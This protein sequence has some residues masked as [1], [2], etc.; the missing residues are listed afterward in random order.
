MSNCSH[1]RSHISCIESVPIFS[2]L[3]SDEML[4]IAHITD[5]ATYNKGDMIYMSG[6][7]GG[8]LYVLH[9][10]R[11]KISR[12]SVNG[13]EQVIRV[14]G[15][16]EFMGELSLLSSLPLN[17]NAEALETCSMCVIDGVK[18]KELMSKYTSIAFKVMDEISK[19]LEKAEQLIESISLNPVEQRL[20]QA[21]LSLSD[22]N[23][24]VVL[25]MTKGEFA[26]L[27]GMSQETLSRKLTFFQD[28][29]LI[30]LKG[31]KRIII[32]NKGSLEALG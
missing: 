13:K 7:M 31:H 29:G 6:D 10:G 22:D 5:A 32:L 15:H 20:A 30:E 14:I 8:K 4:E 25:N 17:E 2:N 16:G 1:K 26:S 24:E 18:L 3:T 11:V 9:T 19:R 27:L 21:L 12:I 28:E 23:N